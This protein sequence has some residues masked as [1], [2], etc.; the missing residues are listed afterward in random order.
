MASGRLA[1]PE[2]TLTRGVDSGTECRHVLK[3][4]RTLLSTCERV[5][6]ETGTLR[7]LILCV[8]TC[9]VKVLSVVCGLSMMS[10][11]GLPSVVRLRLGFSVLVKVLGGRGMSSTLLG[12]ILLKSAL[13]R[14]IRLT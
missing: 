10:R 11:L 4:L 2:T 8:V 12:G 9:V 1:W 13:C 14:R 6:T 5:V 7:I 3:W